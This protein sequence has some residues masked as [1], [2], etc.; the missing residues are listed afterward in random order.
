MKDNFDI[1][2]FKAILWRDIRHIMSGRL[3]FLLALVIR[4]NL[5]DDNCV[6]LTDNASGE[7]ID[8]LRRI[9]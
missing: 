9:F 4:N 1:I 7:D 8:M 6:K 3:K 5:K 2:F